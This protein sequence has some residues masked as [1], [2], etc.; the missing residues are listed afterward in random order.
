MPADDARPVRLYGEV[1]V[2]ARLPWWTGILGLD[3]ARPSQ[4]QK[5]A[6]RIAV[7]AVTTRFYLEPVSHARQPARTAPE[8]LK[9]AGGW[10]RWLASGTGPDDGLLRRFMFRSAAESGV[11]ARQLLPTVQALHNAIHPDEKEKR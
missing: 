4:D 6:A 5:L 10:Y 3:P 8:A 9:E 1:E 11:P 7:A 2:V